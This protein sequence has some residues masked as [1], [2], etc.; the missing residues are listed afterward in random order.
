MNPYLVLDIETGPLSE[1]HQRQIIPTFEA[2]SN[3]KDAEKIKAAIE[4][5]EASWLEAATLDAVRCEVLAIGLKDDM[6]EETLIHGG[7]EKERLTKAIELIGH[8]GDGVNAM[9]PGSIIHHPHIVG[10]RLLAFDIPVLIRRMWAN[11][12]K[13]PQKWLDCTSYRA[14]RQWAFDTAVE[15]GLG[16]RDQYIKL[17]HLAFHLGAG[18]K[19]GDGAMFWKTYQEDPKKALA[20]LSNDLKLTEGCYLKMV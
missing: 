17:D 14:H 20:Y 15:W 3:Y 2:P 16:N 5:K 8:F 4:E 6:G 18:R 10:H 12:I 19:N 9:L 1:E 11:G 13:P 7:T